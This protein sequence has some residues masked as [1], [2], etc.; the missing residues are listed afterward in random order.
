MMQSIFKHVLLF[1]FCFFSLSGF[2][3]QFT[4]KDRAK[5]DSLKKLDYK[6]IYDSYLKIDDDSSTAI[7]FAQAYLEKGKE[8]KDTI[9]IANAYSQIHYLTN[10]FNIR[11]SYSDS[12]LLITKNIKNENYPI[13]GYINKGTDFYY[14][15]NY[16]KAL[17][18]FLKAQ[19]SIKDNTNISHKISILE[20]IGAL[21]NIAGLHEEALSNYLQQ[22]GLFSNNENINDIY[23]LNLYRN[24]A[25]TYIHLRTLDSAD[26][27][28]KKGIKESLKL[29]D[30]LEYYYFVSISGYNEYFKENYQAATDSLQ[31]AFPFDDDH[32]S[33]INY[34]LYKGKIAK[35]LG[36]KEEAI[37]NFEKLDSIYEIHQDPVRE[38]PEVY[39][40]FINYYKEKGD[41]QNQLKYID[42][43]L[44]A[45][46]IL[47]ANFNYLNTKIT[48][49]YDIPLLVAEKETLIKKL[50]NKN[51]QSGLGFL[52]AGGLALIFGSG[53]FY[54][55]RKQK[56]YRKR[57]EEILNS[58]PDQ[59]VYLD[60]SQMSFLRRQESKK[61]ND[62]SQEVIE[63][64]Q[65][66]L[67]KF[68]QEKEFLN[69]TITLHD[70]S[71]KLDTNSNYLSKVI[72]H[73][74]QKNFSNYL[75][76]LRVEYAIEQLKNNKQ[77]RR[78]SVKGMAK[79]IGFNSPDSFSK[80]FYKR[81]GIYPSYFLKQLEKVTK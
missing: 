53:L 46:S 72:N 21:K 1:V 36:K 6:N 57:V 55:Y 32:N 80:A 31:K 25:S 17:T 49:E 61:I 18:N 74:E 5:I 43:L 67:K 62:I 35:D 60:E 42:K 70:L 45:D 16:K 11:F 8:E 59:K 33:R 44:A 3:Q 30:T 73:Y 38:L 4:Q 51:K 54:Y 75:N 76:N 50:E 68:E 28:I 56:F 37:L 63:Q 39:Q 47:D 10:D 14:S 24:I 81:T 77:F 52:I 58:D 19:E 48:K 65:N 22:L 7:V 79:E 69:N 2:S 66:G 13:F 41:I 9:R 20:A 29:N 71:K 12:I 34:H 26:I 23:F 64:I 15:G 78:Y 27:Y 40:T